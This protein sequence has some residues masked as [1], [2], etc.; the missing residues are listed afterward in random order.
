M[1]TCML[2]LFFAFQPVLAHTI[3]V[4]D[5]NDKFCFTYLHIEGCTSI[6]KYYKNYSG[7]YNT[8]VLVESQEIPPAY[9]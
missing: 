1:Y 7:L 9:N 4:Y 8:K 5:T 6:P 2:V 3:H